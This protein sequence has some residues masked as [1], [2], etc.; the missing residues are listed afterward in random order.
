MV[1]YNGIKLFEMVSGEKK[2]LV[3]HFFCV[4]SHKWFYEQI[5]EWRMEWRKHSIHNNTLTNTLNVV[6]CNK[7]LM[8]TLFIYLTV[9]ILLARI[10]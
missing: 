6:L 9:S 7:E 1:Q 5:F 10:K 4:G 2:L 8:N 3:F